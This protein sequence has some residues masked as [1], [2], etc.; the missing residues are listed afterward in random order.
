MKKIKI[1]SF[2][3]L[4]F[5]ALLM[6]GSCSVFSKKAAVRK[7]ERKMAGP[8][9]RSGRVREARG[10]RAAKAAQERRQQKLKRGY[11]RYVRESRKR[12]Y[13]I[14]SPQ[15]RERMKMNEAEIARREK[16]KDKM[17]RESSKKSGRKYR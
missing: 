2:F 11:E 3:L 6:T 8:P 7:V 5:S 9:G 13:E 15:V 14:Q 17:K 4:L 10:V 1:I 16:E 12:S